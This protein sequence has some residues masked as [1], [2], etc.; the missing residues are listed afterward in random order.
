MTDWA[1][2]Q[3]CGLPAAH[4]TT[5]ENAGDDELIVTGLSGLLAE[6][7][8]PLDHDH[9]SA[10][11]AHGGLV[12]HGVLS[13]LS[14]DD[15]T[16]Y[17]LASGSRSLSGN[18]DIGAGR[19]ISGDKI[20]ARSASGLQLFEA[21][22]KGIY[23]LDGGSILINT[24]TPEPTHTLHFADTHA[25]DSDHTTFHI[26]LSLSGTLDG[27]RTQD[28]LLIDLNSAVVGTTAAGKRQTICGQRF[29]LTIDN[30][31]VTYL[32]RC[33]D[34]TI[35]YAS[36]AN[37]SYI[38]AINNIILKTGTGNLALAA[39]QAGS[40]SITGAG[41][42]TT[43][44]GF[45]GQTTL[46]N[47]SATLTT[48]YGIYAYVAQSLGTFSTGYLFYGQFGGTIGTKWGIVCISSAQNRLDG[49]LGL[50]KAPAARLDVDLA[51]EDLQI[52][53]AGTVGA[54]GTAWVQLVVGSTTCYIQCQAAK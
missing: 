6:L 5:H 20:Q 33:V 17:L 45:V 31:G 43:C 14:E 48:G 28:G 42:V 53:D 41:T 35:T 39:A 36:N 19:T 16:Q 27:N 22:G 15:H 25:E 3:C 52:V 11:N 10:G 49:N 30:P 40:I 37:S 50:N 23:I 32:A 2:Y 21:A 7:Q 9:A 8:G 54:T 1:D 12:S 44:Y 38:Y 34:N 46:N 4:H 51:T 26:A 13:N 24:T 47:A 18:W 29:N